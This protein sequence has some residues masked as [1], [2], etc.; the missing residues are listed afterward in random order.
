MLQASLQHPAVLV[1]RGVARKD[2]KKLVT[3]SEESQ[4]KPIIPSQTRFLPNTSARMSECTRG[5]GILTTS[6]CFLDHPPLPPL[7]AFLRAYSYLFN[8][9]RHVRARRVRI[10]WFVCLVG[11]RE[12]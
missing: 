2:H 8:E 12:E 6:L 1:G 9:N 11:Q 5:S 3:E 10:P 7:T 4:P